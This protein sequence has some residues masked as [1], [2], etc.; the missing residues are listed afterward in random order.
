MSKE[1]SRDEV[2]GEKCMWDNLFQQIDLEIRSGWNI[3][4]IRLKVKQSSTRRHTMSE[5]LTN[6]KMGHLRAA[7]DMR[8]VC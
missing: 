1:H 5:R 2:Y 3:R 6:D 8:R 4:I 7:V